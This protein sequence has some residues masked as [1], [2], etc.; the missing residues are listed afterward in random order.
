[1]PIY[2]YR[3]ADC[4]EKS[5]FFVRS[6]SAEVDASCG[7]CGGKDMRRLISAVS[8]RSAGGRAASDSYYGDSSSIGRRVEE[9]YKKFGVDMPNSVRKTIDDARKGK[10]P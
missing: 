8:F 3:C 10:L 4:G 9:S 1:M 7:R 2:E 6:M 5:S